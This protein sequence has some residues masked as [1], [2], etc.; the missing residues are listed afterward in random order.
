MVRGIIIL[1]VRRRIAA[2]RIRSVSGAGQKGWIIRHQYMKC[3]GKKAMFKKTRILALTLG[4]SLVLSQA[5]YADIISPL[6]GDVSST[7][8]ETADANS[9]TDSITY[10][11]QADSSQTTYYAAATEIGSTDGPGIDEHSS[12]DDYGYPGEPGVAAGGT[13]SSDTA[14]SETDANEEV[15]TTQKVLQIDLNSAEA[16]AVTAEAAALY[17]VTH[18]V[19]LYEKNSGDKLAPASITKLLTALLVIENTNMDDMVTFS[20]TATTNLESGATTLNVSEGDTISVK[21]CLYGML[22]HS[23]CEVANGLAEHVGGSIE[24]FCSM[25]NERAAQLGCTNTNFVNPSGLND[26][27]QYTTAHD[28]ALIAAEAFKNETLCEID[29]T[30]TYTFPAVKNASS[31]TITAGDKML[32]PDDSRYYEGIVGGKTGYTS[33]AGNTLVT[34]VEQ[35]GTRLVAVVLKAS[36]SANSYSDTKSMLDYG[37]EVLSKATIEEM[38]TTTGQTVGANTGFTSDGTNTYYYENGSKVYGWKMVDDYY[39]FDP[40]NNGAMVVSNWV[41]DG[42]YWFYCGPEGKIIRNAIIDGQ[43]YVKESGNMATNE[44]IQNG[45][46][47]FYCGSDGKIVKDEII[48]GHYYVDSNGVWD[49]IDRGA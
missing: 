3:K 42:Q 31:R 38:E 32:N 13:A 39:Y 47:W 15:Y 40:N 21:D 8:T 45:S 29:S 12:L 4:L 16:P 10:V 7:G 28:Y 5:A 24:N 1:W 6:T 17:D 11:G 48:D 34:C 18:N 19:F 46:D 35:D 37:F 41:L 23:A 44:W 22:L 49:G 20:S 9:S 14:S 27:N 43:Y 2:S 33:L 25:M 26:P 30:V 36:S